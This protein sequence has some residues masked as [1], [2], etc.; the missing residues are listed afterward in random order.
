M[1]IS[2]FH[3]E[4]GIARQIGH[5][6]KVPRIDFGFCL[7][8]LRLNH[9]LVLFN[10]NARHVWN[11]QVLALIVYGCCKI[12]SACHSSQCAVS[13]TRSDWIFAGS[14]PSSG[15]QSVFAQTLSS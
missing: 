15:G 10:A 1:T 2:A 6:R 13:V 7:N 14:R 12:G 4:V 9:I 11:M 5:V 3:S 8:P